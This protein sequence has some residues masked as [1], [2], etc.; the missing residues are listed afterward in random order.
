MPQNINDLIAQQSNPNDPNA[1]MMPPGADAGAGAPPDPSQDP[2][3]APDQSGGM[4]SPDQMAEL[5]S[6]MQGVQNANS[7][8][9]SK[10]LISKNEISIMRRQLLSSL[11]GL[12]QQAG[13]DPANPGSVKAFLEQ[14]QK[15]DPDLLEIFMAAFH[16]MQNGPQDTNGI[17]PESPQ[18][19]QSIDQGQPEAQEDPSQDQMPPDMSQGQ[20]PMTPP[21]QSGAQGGP[22]TARFHH[23][24]RMGY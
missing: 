23:L 9:V 24:S 20:P 10:Q 15:A 22:I 16:D 14:L 7:K 17:N 13:V 3:Q 4:A 1:Q 21:D 8:L 5:Q 12:L 6:M 18:E 2:T 19:D 11:F